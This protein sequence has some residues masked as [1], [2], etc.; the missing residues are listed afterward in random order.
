MLS[1]FLIIISQIAV[2]R[3]GFDKDGLMGIL[4]YISILVPEFFQFS[5]IY[6]KRRLDLPVFNWPSEGLIIVCL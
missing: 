4:F 5:E 3:L 1:M 6:F 2:M